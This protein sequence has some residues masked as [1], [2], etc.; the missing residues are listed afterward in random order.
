MTRSQ[1]RGSL[2]VYLGGNLLS[3]IVVA[4]WGVGEFGGEV[5]KG[6]GEFG[7]EVNWGVGVLLRKVVL[8][9]AGDEVVELVPLLMRELFEGWAKSGVAGTGSVGLV[10]G[11]LVV[12]LG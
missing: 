10:W 2:L 4:S 12:L 9:G 6:V 7:G 1:K 11:W 5:I 8:S 3:L